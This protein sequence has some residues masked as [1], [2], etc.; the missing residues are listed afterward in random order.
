M[1][2]TKEQISKIQADYIIKTIDILTTNLV[3]TDINV[4]TYSDYERVM[5][6]LRLF[7]A[8]DLKDFNID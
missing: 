6:R 3:R 7:K 4:L 5:N 2:T 1:N 8:T